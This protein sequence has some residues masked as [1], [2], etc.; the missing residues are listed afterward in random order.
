MILLETALPADRYIRQNLCSF[1]LTYFNVWVGWT[2]DVSLH[3]LKWCN[4]KMELCFDH[5]RQLNYSCLRF[6]CTA[7]KYSI[8]KASSGCNIVGIVRSVRCFCLFLKWSLL[9]SVRSFCMRSQLMVL[10]FCLLFFAPQFKPCE[11]C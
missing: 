10:W 9:F 3:G 7:Y 11:L 2:E 8:L 5:G 4:V 6:G 1:L